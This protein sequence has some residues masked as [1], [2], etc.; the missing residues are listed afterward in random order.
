MTST[1]QNNIRSQCLLNTNVTTIWTALAIFCLVL[2]VCSGAVEALPSISTGF[3]ISA[4]P[5][6][7]MLAVLPVIGAPGARGATGAWSIRGWCAHRGYSIAT[8]YKMKKNG[9]APTITSPPSAP[10]RITVESD[11][12]WLKFCENLPAEKAAQA[13]AI[14]ADRKARTLKAGAAAAASP[15]HISKRPHRPVGKLRQRETA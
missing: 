1:L 8:F 3:D 14:S 15:R 4:T 11:L 9:T 10:P 12:A 7:Q 6:A 2:I 13:A 5:L